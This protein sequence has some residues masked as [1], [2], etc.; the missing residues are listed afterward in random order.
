M[1]ERWS[2][3]VLAGLLTAGCAHSEDEWRAKVREAEGLRAQLQDEQARSKKALADEGARLERLTRELRAAGI[4][5]DH[6]AANAEEQARALE[7]HRRR[8]EQLAAAEKRA[9]T[10][11]EK[12]APL[13]KDGVAVTVRHNRLVIQLPGDALFENGREALKRGGKDLLA[14]VA[15]VLRDDRALPARPWQIAGHVDANKPG[16]AFKDGWGLSLMRAR[17]VLAFLVQPVPKGGGGLGASRLSAAGY[18]DADPIDPSGSPEAKKANR[19]CEIVALPA[20][21]ETLDLA[22]LGRH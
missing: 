2:S 4:D 18:G 1:A 10:L 9:A 14:K 7:E 17:E 11:K 19:R 21:E 22:D 20:P 12:L 13:A 16:G 15:A 3:L 5:P 8:G 6:V